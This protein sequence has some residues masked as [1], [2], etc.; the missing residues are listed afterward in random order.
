MFLFFVS[1]VKFFAGAVVVVVVVVAIVFPT[2]HPYH[3][4]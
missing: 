4:L 1:L 3:V 2:Q